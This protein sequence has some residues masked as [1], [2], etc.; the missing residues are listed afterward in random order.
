MIIIDQI[1]QNAL[2]ELANKY[3]LK[4]L[5]LFGSQASGRISQESDYDIAYLSEKNL[6]IEEESQLILDLMPVL[7]V[8][9]E[10]LINLVSMKTRNPLLLYSI[11]HKGKVLFEREPS[12][13]YSL[14]LYAWKVFADSKLFRD[15]C[16]RIIKERVLAM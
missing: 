9:D 5:V 6:S 15:N 7:Q 12:I 10:R 3:E 14:K 4:L 11:T 16:F 13:F 2:G 8:A 1:R